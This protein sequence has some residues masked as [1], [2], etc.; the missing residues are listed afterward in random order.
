MMPAMLRSAPPSS[1]SVL[2]FVSLVV[3]VQG[4][5]SSGTVPLG[6]PKHP[7]YFSTMI[8]KGTF[9]GPLRG[10]NGPPLAGKARQE[11]WMQPSVP[12]FNAMDLALFVNALS[13]RKSSATPAE[14]DRLPPVTSPPATTV[15]L[16]SK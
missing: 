5:G 11:S 1:F 9:L 2:F 7:G 4:G 16:S 10:P 8:D 15:T 12:I 3:S 13:L 14:F 6:P